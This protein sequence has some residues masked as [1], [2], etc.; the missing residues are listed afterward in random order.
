MPRGLRLDA[1]AA[2]ATYQLPCKSAPRRFARCE[3]GP[4]DYPR[5]PEK[6]Q[7]RKTSNVSYYAADVGPAIGDIAKLLAVVGRVF[8]QNGPAAAAGVLLVLAV[9]LGAIW[10]VRR[11]T[12][13]GEDAPPQR[14]DSVKSAILSEK[15]PKVRCHH[16]QHVQAVPASLSTVECDQCNA[17]LK[18]LG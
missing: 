15:P 2:V 18:R 1:P 12:S 6:N 7:E 4:P 17:K 14:V 9:V 8:A 5:G 3:N 16:C 13:N 10:Y 11:R